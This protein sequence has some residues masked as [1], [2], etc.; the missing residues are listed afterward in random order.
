[1]KGK[2]GITCTNKVATSEPWQPESGETS[3]IAIKPHGVPARWDVL[4]AE[5]GRYCY[6]CDECKEKLE[7][8]G[9]GL[10]FEKLYEV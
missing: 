3:P 1:M 5:G 9:G 7:A 6:A 10:K 4:T 8:K 2:K